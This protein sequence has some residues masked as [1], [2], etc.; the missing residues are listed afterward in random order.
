MRIVVLDG[1]TANP[2]D[3]DWRELAA[4]GECTVH[5]RT[6]RELTVARAADAPLVLTNKVVLDA[7]V[8]A[9]LPALR[10]VGVL[11]T[12]YNVVDLPA[13]DAR[14]IVVTN[15]PAYSTASVVQLTFGLLLELTLGVGHHARA[16]HEGRWAASPDFAFYDW[17]LV[18][19]DGLTL[20]I[21]GFGRIGQAVAR[22]AQA[23]GMS[24]QAHVRS[25]RPAPD[26]VRFV[27]LDTLFATSDV[28][29]CHCPLTPET[30]GLVNAERL[31][32][33]KP[34]AY[35]LNTSRGPVVNESDLAAAL[36]AGRLAGA[37]V[38]VLSTE[39]PAAD[40][41]LLTAR[42]CVITPH[43][44]WATQA[45]RRRLMAIAA[46]NVRAFLAGVPTNVVNHPR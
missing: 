31:A 13:A 39:P 2:G 34:S 11:A 17:P 9:A 24:V 35:L 7:A 28:V 3:L 5:A 33:M 14:G 44:A 36:N 25:P 4:L 20:G 27:D 19:L 26:G 46:A 29:S 10:Y 38:D 37:G 16:V 18:E 23:L 22:V 1:H 6:P 15:I 40:N 45:A 32:R 21:V 43:V 8:L 12:G 42:N 41:P 30:A